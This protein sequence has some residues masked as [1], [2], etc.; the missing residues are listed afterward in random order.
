MS[1][2]AKRPSRESRAR[3][4]RIASIDAAPALRLVDD[5]ADGAISY[6]DSP[7][8]LRRSSNSSRLGGCVCGVPGRS[9]VNPSRQLA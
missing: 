4:R 5:G 8:V 1:F 7:I 2:G 6:L 9:K 3:H